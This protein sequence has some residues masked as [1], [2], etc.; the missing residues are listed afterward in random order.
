MRTGLTIPFEGLS[1]RELP[2]LVRR[3]E[4]AGY[5]SVWTAE[6]TGLMCPN[7]SQRS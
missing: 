7:L 3:A 1:F 5:E 4:A 6:S 2:E